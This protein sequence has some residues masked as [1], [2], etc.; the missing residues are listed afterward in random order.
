MLLVADSGSTKCDW[1]VIEN[2]KAGT[3]LSTGG[4]NPNFCDAAFILDELNAKE[5]LADIRNKVK[6]IRFFGSGCSGPARN[7]I[8]SQPLQSFFPKADVEVH[9]DVLGAALATCGDQPGISCIIGTGCNASLFDGKDVVPNNFGLGYVLADEGSGTYLGKK[10]ITA[11]LYDTLPAKLRS[12]FSSR[13]LLDR[14]SVIE[15]VYSKPR[16]NIWLASFAAFL[17]EHSSEAWVSKTVSKGFQDF[18]DLYICSQK[19][20]RN[21]PASFVGSVAFGFR[22]LL[23]EVAS[24][25]GVT[26]GK[27]IRYPIEGLADYYS[28]RSF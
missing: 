28:N 26:I 11:Y 22:E 5:G 14:E 19:D 12:D 6:F 21:L 17:S 7:A 27:I 23:H 3:K 4:F 9:H 25:N 8:V 15:H 18:F 13:Y 1:I 16:A 2:G 20:Y 10:L 24:E